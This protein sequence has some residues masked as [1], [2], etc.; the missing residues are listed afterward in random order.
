MP[1]KSS[2][3]EGI[4]TPDPWFRS[5]MNGV[6]L[7]VISFHSV[8]KSGMVAYV[9]YHFVLHR[10]IRWI[11]NRLAEKEMAAGWLTD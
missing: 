2:A 1:L 7:G 4:R 11:S 6:P 10:V 3:P 9:L 5:P 8:H